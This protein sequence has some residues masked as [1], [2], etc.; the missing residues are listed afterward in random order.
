M[1]SVLIM[2]LQLSGDMAFQRVNTQD[3]ISL[4]A[5]LLDS[6]NGDSTDEKTIEVLKKGG[7][8]D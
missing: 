3:H 1:L 8:Q 2:K 5:I 6:K 7:L 4:K